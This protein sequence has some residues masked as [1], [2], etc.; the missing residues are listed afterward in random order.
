MKVRVYLISN[1]TIEFP[2]R[3]ISN[4]R[5]IAKR[6]IMEGLWTEQQ[7]DGTESF[8]PVHQVYKVKVIK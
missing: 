8:Y 1:D 6:I 3:D 7:A 2:A 4:A 5:E